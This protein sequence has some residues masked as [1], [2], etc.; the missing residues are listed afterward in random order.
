MEISWYGLSCFRITE[1]QHATV[2]TDP[3]DAS[4]GLTVPKLKGDIVTTSHNAGGHNNV[5]AVPGRQHVLT[6]P[7]EYEI[8][9]VFVTGI[10]A[11]TG[12]RRNVVFRFDFDGLTV[13]HLGDVSKVL[14][15]QQIE[16]LSELEQDWRQRQSLLPSRSFPPRWFAGSQRSMNQTNAVRGC[17]K[18]SQRQRQLPA[19]GLFE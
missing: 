11:H 1:R 12:K 7:G 17:P 15:Q 9:N 8:G 4:I 14:N 2:I 13:A 3:F 18:H 10:A 16:K 6:G 19:K 5:T